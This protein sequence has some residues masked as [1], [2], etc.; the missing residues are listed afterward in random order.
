MLVSTITLPNLKIIRSAKQLHGLSKLIVISSNCLLS[1]LFFSQSSRKTQVELSNLA[2]HHLFLFICLH[3]T[4]KLRRRKFHRQLTSYPV[5]DWVE[6]SK[7][8][9][10]PP[11]QYLQY[12]ICKLIIRLHSNKPAQTRETLPQNPHSYNTAI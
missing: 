4:L 5:Y 11:G 1:L 10:G 8:E 7:S 3:V 9:S 6:Y 12:I 2:C